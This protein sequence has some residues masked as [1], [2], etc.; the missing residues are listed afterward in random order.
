[1]Q[2]IVLV[3]AEQSGDALDKQIDAVAKLSPTWVVM[4]GVE[5]SPFDRVRSQL[6][7]RCP[8]LPLFGATSFR[9][10]FTASGFIRK[11]CL[12]VGE[13]ND[14]VKIAVSL[15]QCRAS[16]AKERAQKACQELETRLGVRPSRLVLHAT[17]GFEE[18][19]LEGVASAFGKSVPVFGGSATDDRSTG[20]WSVF[21]KSGTVK[22]GFVLAGVVSAR[23]VQGAFMGGFLPT[24]H[25]GTVT[26]VE[27]RVIHEIDGHPAADVYNSW[28]GGAISSELLSGGSIVSKTNLRP[29]SRSVGAAHGMER[30]IL[31][32]PH[33]VLLPS[34][35]MSFYTEFT[36][37]EPVTLMTSTVDPLIG[38]VAR[39]VERARGARARTPYGGLFVYCAGSLSTMLDHA[40][41]ICKEYALAL[42]GAPFLGIATAGEQGAFFSNAESW[43]G[44]LMCSTLL[45]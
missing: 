13:P 18:R 27:G 12:L 17:P 37:A 4:Y 11:V 45:F 8:E 36:R 23:D 20:R 32:H 29:L 28:T 7:S 16:L 39:T 14:G 2:A 34:R 24:E 35:S 30:R 41:R 42:G 31:A 22:D 1:M 5:D 6:L 21:A 40:D 33:E 9:G 25:T 3:S 38:R 19:I 15:Q 10:V 44:N 43:H 26:K